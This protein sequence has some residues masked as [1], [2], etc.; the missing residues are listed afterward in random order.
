MELGVSAP[1]AE[2]GLG[3]PGEFH[4]SG[5]IFPIDKCFAA[6]FN[7]GGNQDPGRNKAFWFPPRVLGEVPGPKRAQSPD[8]VPS[9]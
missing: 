1:K 8:P 6:H 5:S 3:V 9:R 2:L 7:S 4:L